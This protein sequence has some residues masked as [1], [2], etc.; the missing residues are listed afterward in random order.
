M[1]AEATR[2]PQE[3]AC[4]PAF[5][6]G[7]GASSTAPSNGARTGVSPSKAA[8]SPFGETHEARIGAGQAQ[9]VGAGDHRHRNLVVLQRGLG[10]VAARRRR[11]AGAGIHQAMHLQ[12][13]DRDAPGGVDAGL[14]EVLA[15]LRNQPDGEASGR[16]KAP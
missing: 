12:E 4:C 16:R 6:A 14:G 3:N 10:L 2:R 8:T 11:I 15:A 9:C 13:P 7:R 1:A 5:G